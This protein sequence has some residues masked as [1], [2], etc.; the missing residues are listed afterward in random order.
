MQKARDPGAC[1]VDYRSRADELSFSRAIHQSGGP[2]PRGALDLL[3]ACACE[4]LRAALGCVE[5]I[6][7]HQARI[8]GPSIGVYETATKALLQRRAGR[9]LAKIDRRG[10]R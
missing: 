4:N 2:T 7:G 9:M 1:C 6:Q 8:V 3:A 5:R 10:A